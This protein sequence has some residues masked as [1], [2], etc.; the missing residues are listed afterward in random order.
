MK[1]NTKEFYE[2]M[3]QFEKDV[4]SIYI[5]KGSQG[6]KKEDKENWDRQ[7]YYCDGEVNNC[8]KLYIMGY[9]FGKSCFIN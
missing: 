3:Q 8:F 5:R 6:L 1:N 7:N 2:I 4:K 9:S